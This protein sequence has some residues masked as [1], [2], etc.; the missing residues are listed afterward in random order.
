MNA[1]VNAFMENKKFTLSKD[2]CNVLHVG[3]VQGKCFTQKVH[4]EIMN[5]VDG[6]KYLGDIIYKN[7]KVAS[8]MS[9]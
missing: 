2:K 3:K 6:T 1:T 5:Q 7:G 4:N 8:N 9:D